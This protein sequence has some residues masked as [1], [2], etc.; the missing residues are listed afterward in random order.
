MFIHEH[1]IRVRYAETDQMGLVHH[2]SYVLYVEEARTEA[3]R[4]LGLTY[5]DMED[6]GIA[7][8]VHS[9]NFIFKIPAYYDDLLKVVTKIEEPA[10][11]RVHFDYEIFNQHNQLLSNAKVTLFFID[12]ISGRPTRCP[13]YLKDLLSPFF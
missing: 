5:K 13:Q 6:K 1:S 7:M 10:Q 9:M 11:S 2:S 12:R 3:L 4:T 8:P